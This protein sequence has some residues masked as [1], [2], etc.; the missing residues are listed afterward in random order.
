MKKIFLLFNFLVFTCIVTA[1]VN[2]SSMF[3]P[4]D[5]KALL[6]H[7][8]ISDKTKI[9]PRFLGHG[10]GASEK[11]T[12]SYSNW[13]NYWSA[14]ATTAA[15]SYYYDVYPDSNI[16]HMGTTYNFLEGM[17]SSFDPTDSGYYACCSP[18]GLTGPM[19][20]EGTGYTVDSFSVVTKYI[21]N[22][23]LTT[24][25]DSIIIELSVALD[26]V[27]SGMFKLFFQDPDYSLFGYCA[28]SFA[29][30]ADANYLQ[31]DAPVASPFK[32]EIWDS[33]LVPKKYRI[34]YGLVDGSQ[35][36]TDAYGFNVFLVAPPVPIQVPPGGKVV[37]YV[38]F[39]TGV[40]YPFG[41]S[42]SFAN[43]LRA[44]C[45][46]P[47]GATVWPRQS[48]HNAAI[49]YKGSYNVGVFSESSTGYVG[50]PYFFKYEGH[51]LLVP[52]NAYFGPGSVPSGLEVPFMAF[53]LRYSSVTTDAEHI[54][55]RRKVVAQPN[56]A[57]TE[58]NIS[59][60]F[61]V[62][63]ATVTLMNAFG[64]VMDYRQFKADN[65]V[66]LN[67]SA[68]PAGIYYYVVNADGEHYTGRVVV[69]H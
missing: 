17:G 11:T 57:N 69:T 55:Q 66:V 20:L 3:G 18:S 5:Q 68:L 29:R 64:Q 8:H 40:N 49:G 34:A 16:I 60:N 59:L 15:V 52:A 43:Y 46:S 39:K 61:M 63:D 65:K 50:S 26:S 31:H 6:S 19:I 10:A 44:Y 58:I 24:I 42:D 4:L 14:A 47:G 45:G 21:R 9:D 48:A 2:T 13:F 12:S 33:I 30:F 41:T 67:T 7:R 56:P 27:D 51:A 36:D 62:S 23:P 53:H 1:Q 35:N 22:N 32:N 37:S 38:S 25:S 28:D 54:D